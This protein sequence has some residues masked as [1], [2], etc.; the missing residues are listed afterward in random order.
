M[1]KDRDRESQLLEKLDFLIHKHDTLSKEIADLRDEIK[2]YK[3]SKS[4]T[5]DQNAVIQKTILPETEMPQSKRRTFNRL[6]LGRGRNDNQQ[7]T[8]IDLEKFVGENLINKIGIIITVIGVSIGVK[9]AIAHELI[10]PLTRIILGYLVGFGLL[11]FAFRLKKEYL[12]FSSVLLSGSMAIL[13]FITYAAYSFYNLF[14]QPVAFAIMVL[15]TIFTVFSAL[16]YNKQ[17]IAH[18]GL[19]G[20]YAIPFLLSKGPDRV[21]I[22]FSY[23]TIINLGILSV[24]LKRY[25]KPIYFSSFILTWAV[26]FQAFY[27][28]PQPG[29]HIG[30]LFPFLTVFFVIFYLEFL[31]YKL[32]KKEKFNII[33]ILLLLANSFIYFGNGY[34]LLDKH[35]SYQNL[36]GLFALGNATIHGAVSLVIYKQKL[37][38]QNLFH[39]VLG[40]ALTFITIAGPVQLDGNWVTLFW[41]GE[42]VVLFWIGRTQKRDFY[43]L[44]SYPVIIIAFLSLL[45]DWEMFY[46]GLFSASQPVNRLTPFFNLCFLTGLIV[47]AAFAYI[48]WLYNHKKYIPP[49]LPKFDLLVLVPFL[50]PGLLL[51]VTYFTFRLEIAAFWNHRFVHTASS[52]IVNDTHQTIVLPDRDL[53]RFETVT[54]INYSLLFFTLLTYA[55]IKWIK[56]SILGYFCLLLIT[57]SVFAF[58]T[59]GLASLGILRDSYI[60]VS[61]EDYFQPNIFYLLTRYISYSF[62]TLAL[63]ALFKGIQQ[64]F[65]RLKLNLVFDFV[66]YSTALWIATSELIHWLHIASSPQ[67]NKLG[68]SIL[69]GIYSLLLV[70]TGIWKKK[71]HLRISAMVLFGITLMK[72]FFYDLINLD[73]ISKTI[74]F[75]SLGILLLIISFLYNKYTKIIT[76][77][78]N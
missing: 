25:W 44:L 16:K 1:T 50:L 26:Y 18:F 47:I 13:Y 42:A 7:A 3:I 46:S 29:D 40:L 30:L 14:A 78:T 12:N 56:K 71:K 15:I 32:L 2:Q 31:G 36:V 54:V 64:D 75:V 20:A 68:V 65:I 19:V 53:I 76:G 38:D 60:N 61:P 66:L 28:Y 17:V 72:L 74:L 5:D 8:R 21:D 48:N 35:V 41:T 45:Q 11:A 9:Y 4:L 37:A 73:T 67:P 27:F 58:L 10:S 24:A 55:N 23:M 57:F 33:D 77:E 6:S 59:D 49:Q 70:V 43:E 51:L 52:V 62:V 63:I 22:L 34:E 39:F 69:W